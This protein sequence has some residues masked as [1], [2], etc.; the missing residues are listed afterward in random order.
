MINNNIIL[1]ASN[2]FSSTNSEVRKQAVW[3]IG[4]LWNMEFGRNQLEVSF[5]GL[6]K[7]LID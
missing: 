6:K 5:N 4:S 2:L 3:L 1:S 7:L